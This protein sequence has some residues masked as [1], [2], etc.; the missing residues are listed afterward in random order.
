MICSRATEDQIEATWHAW[1]WPGNQYLH[2][3]HT[4]WLNTHCAQYWHHLPRTLYFQH[5]SDLHTWSVAHSLEPDLTHR[6]LLDRNNHDL[7]QE[8]T[9]WCEQQWGADLFRGR[10]WPHGTWTYG[11]VIKVGTCMQ[12]A[13]QEQAVQFALVFT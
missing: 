1:K 5:E 4:E 3:H 10:C 8:C 12:F 2:R 7:I 11:Y 9:R 13:H 6:V